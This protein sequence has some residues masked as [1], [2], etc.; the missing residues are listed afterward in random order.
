MRPVKQV[1]AELLFDVIS[2]AYE[3]SSVI[4]TTS[5]PFE[6][7]TEVLGSKRMAG[8][9]LDR[10]THRCLILEPVAKVIACRTPSGAA[11]GRLRQSRRE[12]GGWRN[13][14]SRFLL[15]RRNRFDSPPSRSLP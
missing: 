6:Q 14:R 8:G 10:L 4:M 2:A 5:L 7:W 9:M 13:R 3:R 1:A 11:A 12:W 15:R